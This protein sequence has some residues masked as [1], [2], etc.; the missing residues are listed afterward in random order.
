MLFANMSQHFCL[1]RLQTDRC[2]KPFCFAT[3]H[4]EKGILIIS[5]ESKR[6]DYD[7]PFQ[8]QSRACLKGSMAQLEHHYLKIC[9]FPFYLSS[10]ILCV[11]SSHCALSLFIQQFLYMIF[12]HLQATRV[13]PSEVEKGGRGGGIICRIFLFA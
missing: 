13:T 3:S 6:M 12:W 2:G 1:K 7:Y 5:I 10:H 9:D 4:P 8:Y 11:G